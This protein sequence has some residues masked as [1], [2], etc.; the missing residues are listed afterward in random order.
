MIDADAITEAAR[1]AGHTGLAHLITN[2]GAISPTNAIESAALAGVLEA[3][4]LHGPDIIDRAVLEAR[5]ALDPAEVLLD[6][7]ALTPQA[8]AEI[9]DAALEDEGRN[10][11]AV[12][13][14]LDG[15]GTVLGRVL[16]AA[17]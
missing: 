11:Q 2:L 12:L 4:R 13:L 7:T 8:R 6:T 16:R 17:I 1:K 9:A 15:V 3:A 5:H 14:F 10:H